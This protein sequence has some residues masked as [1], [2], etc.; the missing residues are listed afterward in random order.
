M[1]SLKKYYFKGLFDK[2]ID[3][4]WWKRNAMTYL[5]FVEIRTSKIKN[6]KIKSDFKP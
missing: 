4:A 3:V 1:I 6:K 2:N 5:K